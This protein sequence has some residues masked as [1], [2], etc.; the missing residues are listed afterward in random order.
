M[1]RSKTVDAGIPEKVT[2]RAEKMSRE[3]LIAWSDQAI[4]T[5][6]RCLTQYSREGAP[7][8]LMDAL[9]G[10]QVLLATVQEI[11]RRDRL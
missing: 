6:G 10:A 7:E 2:S 3:D 9:T 5:T 4:Y 1:F 8:H 11:R